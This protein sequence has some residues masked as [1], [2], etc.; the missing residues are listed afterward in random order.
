MVLIG[1]IAALTTLH[2]GSTHAAMSGASTVQT[3]QQP[4]GLSRQPSLSLIDREGKEKE[5]RGEKEGE[6]GGETE[7]GTTTAT[8][9]AAQAVLAQVEEVSILEV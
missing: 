7:T 4:R 6:R 8:V 9:G 1:H 2:P 5:K 3:Q